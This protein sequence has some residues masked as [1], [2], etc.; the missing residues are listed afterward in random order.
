M[1]MKTKKTTLT[2]TERMDELWRRN[3]ER[4]GWAKGRR[5]GGAK[6][7]SAGVLFISLVGLVCRGDGATTL[8][9]KEYDNVTILE[10]AEVC[11][12]FYDRVGRD[13]LRGPPEGAEGPEGCPRG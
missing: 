12:G 1:K 6:Y 13:Q 8:N 2:T 10:G 5:G 4:R 3:E 7:D 11:I 9:R